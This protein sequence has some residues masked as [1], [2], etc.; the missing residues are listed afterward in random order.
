MKN[1]ILFALLLFF[2]LKY[3]FACSCGNA[4][5][6]CEIYAYAIANDAT[7]LQGQPEK[8]IGHGMIFKVD[9]VFSSPDDVPKKITVWGDPG[10]LCR[11]YVTG[12]EKQDKLV[13]ILGAITQERT[14]NVTGFTEKVGDYA[15][16]VCG[17]FF[18]YLNGENA[19]KPECVKLSGKKPLPIL[20]FPNPT[21]NAFTMELVS[22]T[23]EDIRVFSVDGRL[24]FSKE[25]LN[26]LAAEDSIQ[27]ETIHWIAGIYII[28]IKTAEQS[29]VTKIIKL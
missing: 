25:Q 16:S 3:V 20:S 23:V 1:T 6:F 2:P 7:I 18:V 21:I 4:G 12:F 19:Q 22:S 9:K 24:L 29:W 17:E 10:Y 11:T 28:E 13:L 27:I 26:I 15:L 8:I 14:E 5:D